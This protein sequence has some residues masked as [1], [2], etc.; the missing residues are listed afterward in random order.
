[1]ATKLISF[2]DQGTELRNLFAIG[3]EDK[4]RVGVLII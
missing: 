4:P 3:K 1:V 2:Q